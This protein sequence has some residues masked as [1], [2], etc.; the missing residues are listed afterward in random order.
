MAG[1]LEKV[2]EQILLEAKEVAEGKIK[3]AQREAQEIIDEAEAEAK[4]LSEEAQQKSADE[5]AKYKER[6]H[7]ASDME[8]RTQILNAKQEMIASVFREALKRVD[9]MDAPEYSALLLRIL[10]GHLKPE[11]GVL[12]FSEADLGR[13][14]SEFTEAA[15]AEAISA[16]GSLEIGL[17]PK[18]IKNGFVLAYGEIEENCTITA[19]LDDKKDDLRD[20]L[21]KLLFA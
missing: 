18:N 6:S 11:A 1:G 12:Y 16:G 15:K 20:E 2:K 7:A 13:L 10:K 19:L 14:T 17:E 21:N 5:T 9:E 4:K 3:E 8:R